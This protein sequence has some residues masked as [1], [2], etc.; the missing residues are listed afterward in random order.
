MSYK[1]FLPQ[2]AVTLH[3]DREITTKIL[4]ITGGRTPD[5]AWLKRTANQRIIYCADH[6]LD[7]CIDAGLIPDYILGDGDSVDS[8]NWQWAESIGIPVDKYPSA[9]NLLIHTQLALEQ[10]NQKYPQSDIII[11]GMFGGRFDHLY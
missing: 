4:L 10:I 2:L 6:G 7:I 11:T 9:K 5:T 1:I 3:K 8:L